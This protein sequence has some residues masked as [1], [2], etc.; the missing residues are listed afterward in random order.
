[1]QPKFSQKMNDKECENIMDF[2]LI[3]VMFDL[4]RDNILKARSLEFMICIKNF[5]MFKGCD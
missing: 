3:L 4:T 1:M 5:F 2:M